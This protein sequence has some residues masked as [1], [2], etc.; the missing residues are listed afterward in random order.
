MLKQRLLLLP[1]LRPGL[2][3]QQTHIHAPL[4]QNLRRHC[5]QDQTARKAECACYMPDDTGVTFWH[6]GDC[7]DCLFAKADQ[8]LLEVVEGYHNYQRIDAGTYAC[9]HCDEV[10][11]G[12][13]V[14]VC[15][16]GRLYEDVETAF[17]NVKTGS[18]FQLLADA[19]VDQLAVSGYTLDL[20]G[21]TISGE[22]YTSTMY[23]VQDTGKLTIS[24]CTAY[25]D[26][27]GVILKHF[28]DSAACARFLPKGASLLDVG[29]GAGFP[30]HVKFAVEPER[31]NYLIIN[32]AECEPYVTSDTLTRRPS[33]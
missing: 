18:D 23:Y 15:L 9:S 2:G 10:Y 27:N 29:C 26:E 1:D 22:S 16:D 32:G 28:A 17:Q 8:T 4:C 21:Y 13:N 11:H 31:I 6:K 14:V 33:A 12:E 24:D 20:N 7:T 30:T 5:I 25:T 3:D 19:Q